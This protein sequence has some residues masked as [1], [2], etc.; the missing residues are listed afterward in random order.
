MSWL[1]KFIQKG[2]TVKGAIREFFTMN[3]RMPRTSEMNKILQAFGAKGNFPKGWTPKVIEGGKSEPKIGLG[4][5]TLGTAPK[6]TPKPAVDPRLQRWVDQQEWAAKKRAENKASLKRFE[7]KFGKPEDRASGG[8]VRVGYGKGK[9]VKGFF[10]F[11]EGLFIKASNDIRQG[12]GLFKNLTDKQKWAQHDNLTKMVEKWQK[13]KKLPEGAE[14]YFGID[15]EKA[16]K[17]KTGEIQPSFSLSREKLVAQFPNIPEGKINR[18]MKLPVDEQKKILTKLMSGQKTH[19]K[20]TQ[21]QYLE[22]LDNRI[23]DEMD[24]TKSEM[25]NMS[26]TALDDLRRNADPQ[27]MQTHFDEITEGRGV[28]DF[29]DDLNF[30]KD[31][32]AQ[33]EILEQFDVTGKKGHAYGGIAGQLHLNEGGRARFQTGGYTYNPNLNPTYMKN[34]LAYDE[35]Y[36]KGHDLQSRTGYEN[37]LDLKH[38]LG[39]DIG[40]PLEQ[41]ELKDYLDKIWLQSESQQEALKTSPHQRLGSGSPF[42]RYSPSNMSA[43]NMSNPLSVSSG[44]P[45]YGLRKS[46]LQLEEPY[47]KEFIK[48]YL[49]QLDQA[50]IDHYR[51]NM[52]DPDIQKQIFGGEQEAAPTG[53][54]TIPGEKK[55]FNVMMDEKGNVADDQGIAELA[56]ETGMAPG[57][58]NLPINSMSDLQR[59]IGPGDD[60]SEGTGYN[61]P[62]PSVEQ[63]MQAAA[64][65]GLD[66]RMGRTYAE[67]IQAM[68]DPRMR[69]PMGGM[70]VDIMPPSN[71]AGMRG[72]FAEPVTLDGQQF[73]NE[74]DAIAGLGVERYNQL[75]ATGGRVRF[76]KGGLDKGRRNF[77]KL[78]GGL[79]SIPILGKYFKLA[80]PATKVMTA[81]EKSNAVGM[82]KWF[83]SL[84]NKVMKEGKDVSKQYATTERVIVKQAELPNS[85]TK[86]LVEQDLTTGNTTVDVG[87]DKH[88]WVDGYHGQPVRL[89]L[90]K[91]EWIEPQVS[92]TGKVK[93]KA[94]KTKDEFDVEE[95]EF[96][97][98]AESVKYEESSFEKFGKHGSDFSEVEKYATGKV[99]KTKPS[100][101]AERAHWEPDYAKGGLAGVLRL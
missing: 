55:S 81:L 10:E 15:A 41:E 68:A 49:S 88:G 51:Y 96:T 78:M 61:M 74:A 53:I 101:K 60:I 36:W 95:A 22:D 6:T 92:K 50:Y 28:G 46:L 84:V 19:T 29:A 90:K 89:H 37:I 3:G 59:M 62:P 76:D 18:I 80:K 45:A 11:V 25:D 42:F 39:K 58:T 85:K 73:T 63:R 8:I 26:S 38:V 83:P 47:G 33:T 17:I 91:G 94:V 65:K 93:K 40:A 27:G 75:M 98:D 4:E 30:M 23:M 97:G 7:D 1:I 12:K 70:P 82:P 67:N 34:I 32:Y 57:I 99:T 24:L 21:Q 71:T 79:A 43:Y 13:T 2:G 54:Q 56:R 64:A 44:L 14:Q 86:V 35:P 16:F 66:P 87:L 20:L 69:P 52:Q 9:L 77:L 31:D 5:F 48:P 72:G 100:I